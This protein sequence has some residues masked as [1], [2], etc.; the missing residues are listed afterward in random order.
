M[1]SLSFSLSSFTVKLTRPLNQRGSVKGFKQRIGCLLRVCSLCFYKAVVHVNIMFCGLFL[2]SVIV[3]DSSYIVFFCFSTKVSAEWCEQ[4]DKDSS[5]VY[6]QLQLLI[7]VSNR[8]NRYSD[9]RIKSDRAC[10]LFHSSGLYLNNY[11]THL[12]DQ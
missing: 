12:K 6:L 2:S 11:K 9:V 1:S 3:S 4:S 8:F 10:F 5:S 7:S